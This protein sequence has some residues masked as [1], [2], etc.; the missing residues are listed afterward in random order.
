MQAGRLDV[1]EF[2]LRDAVNYFEEE[3]INIVFATIVNGHPF[4]RVLKK[5]G[6]I[7]SR[8]KPFLGINPE[9]IDNDEL[10]ALMNATPDK[11]NYQYGEFDTI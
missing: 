8:E 1:A 10:E 3:S 4:E 9:N 11:L 5:Y 6:F 7:D 2:L